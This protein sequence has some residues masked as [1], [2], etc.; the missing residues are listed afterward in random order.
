MPA[1]TDRPS[2]PASAARVT[3]AAGHGPGDAS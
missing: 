2:A 3:P 1:P